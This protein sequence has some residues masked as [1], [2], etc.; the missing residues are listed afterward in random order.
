MSVDL[1]AALGPTSA[2]IPPDGMREV[3]SPQG[4]DPAPVSLGQPSGLEDGR[5]HRSSDGADKQRE[6]VDE[7]RQPHE[8]EGDRGG[9]KGLHRS[10]LGGA[11]MDRC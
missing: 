1:P 5:L 7:G 10:D 6:E 11:L 8:G 3:D 9:A 2:V 4:P